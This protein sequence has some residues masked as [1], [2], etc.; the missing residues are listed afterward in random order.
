VS[1]VERLGLAAIL[2]IAALLRL[3]DLGGPELGLDERGTLVVVGQ[4]SLLDALQGDV[5]PPLGYLLARAG[6]ALEPWLGTEAGL[7]LGSAL[8]GWLAVPAL[9]AW[10]RRRAGPRAGLLAAAL[11]A[12]HGAAVGHAREARFY[13]LLLLLVILMLHLAD[14]VAERWRGRDG[15]LLGLL[16]AGVVLSHTLGAALVAARGAWLV[17]QAIRARSRGIVAPTDATVLALATLL[18]CLAPFAALWRTHAARLVGAP[19]TTVAVSMRVV[20]GVV[21]ELSGVNVALRSRL[22][23]VALGPLVLAG[24]LACVRR[25]RGE[26]PAWLVLSVGG[27]VLGF[28]LFPPAQLYTRYFEWALPL[29]LLLAARGALALSDLARRA[30]GRAHGRR[31]LVG[32]AA[33]AV[34]ALCH[35][36]VEGRAQ[37]ALRL[38]EAGAWL[39]ARVGPGDRVV[40]HLHRATTLDN[41]RG[42]RW[43][44]QHASP[45]AVA[46]LCTTPDAL[47]L[48]APPA[49]TF[50]VILTTPRWALP[51]GAS[52]AGAVVLSRRVVVVEPDPR[53]AATADALRRLAAV[54]RLL[55]GH[56]EAAWRWA[57]ARWHPEA[58]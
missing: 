12:V 42:A 7:R 11:L 33:F 35:A 39:A 28:W 2:A 15:V 21:R 23:V 4:P 43:E 49:R 27:A 45:A 51:E 57:F 1:R 54:D 55:P 8:A 25:R 34:A 58:R 56:D 3:V 26:E 22:G 32:L 6:L 29:W 30:R 19:E 38:R 9:W 48:D 31:A 16:G 52:V 50:G 36:S 20:E 46:S 17:G 14:R 5:A 44:L 24:A 13:A 40:V 37:P 18:V 10:V 47:A 53:D 41:A